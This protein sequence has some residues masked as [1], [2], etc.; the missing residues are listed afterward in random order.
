MFSTLPYLRA[1]P[2]QEGLHHALRRAGWCCDGGGLRGL[3]AWRCVAGERWET[4][5]GQPRL[6]LPRACEA[7][8]E[9]TCHSLTSSKLESREWECGSVDRHIKVRDEQPATLTR[10][11]CNQPGPGCLSRTRAGV[12]ATPELGESTGRPLQTP[13]R[14]WHDSCRRPCGLLA[15]EPPKIWHHQ[16]PFHRIGADGLTLS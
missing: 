9:V 4:S 7:C 10:R 12:L 16:S 2:A 13:G 11:R 5:R 3:V 1:K 15:R 6:W 8:F 14:F